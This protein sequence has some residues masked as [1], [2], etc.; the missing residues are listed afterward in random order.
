MLEMVKSVRHEESGYQ[1]SKP[2]F[3]CSSALGALFDRSHLYMQILEARVRLLKYHEE[4]QLPDM[5]VLHANV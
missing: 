1:P 2:P 3:A 4:T 5:Q